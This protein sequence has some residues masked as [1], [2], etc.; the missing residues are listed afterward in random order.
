[1]IYAQG[2]WEHVRHMHPAVSKDMAQSFS[3]VTGVQGDEKATLLHKLKK[4]LLSLRSCVRATVPSS[5]VTEREILV[6]G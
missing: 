1:M 2:T 3:R 6:T 4:G 5:M